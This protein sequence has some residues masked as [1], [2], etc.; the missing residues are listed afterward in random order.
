MRGRTVT[1]N[2]TL[3]GQ[4]GLLKYDMTILLL[5]V[6]NNN[7]CNVS[8]V[9]FCLSV[10]LHNVHKIKSHMVKS[11]SNLTKFEMI[12]TMTIGIYVSQ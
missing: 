10:S 3:S 12:I 7:D 8:T 9:L 2:L 4:S 11:C 1:D 5:S 6:S